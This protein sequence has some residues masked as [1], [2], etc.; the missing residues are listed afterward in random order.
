MLLRR[1]EPVTLRKPNQIAAR[2]TSTRKSNVAGDLFD[3]P[4]NAG[5]GSSVPIRPWEVDNARL[6]DA[7]RMRALRSTG[8]LDSPPE[9]AYDAFVQRASDRLGAPISLVSLVDTDR[10]FF[11]AAV[12][13]TEPVATARETPLTHSICQYAVLHREPVVVGDL[14]N[15]P[16]LAANGAVTELGMGAYAGAPLITR[17]GHVLGALCV[18]DTEPREWTADQVETL[19]EMAAEVV[20]RIERATPP[21]AA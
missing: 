2:T 20:E 14:R 21:A 3:I 9:P 1:N 8:L 5:Y 18:I 4:A 15:H 13:L 10:Q 17:D 12:G 19:T 16:Q 11:K 7:G 6:R